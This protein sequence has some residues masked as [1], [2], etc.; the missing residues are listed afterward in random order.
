MRK[1]RHKGLDIFSASRCRRGV[2]T[3]RGS[4]SRTSTTTSSAKNQAE[5]WDD[6]PDIKATWDRLGI[7]EAEKN[8]LAGVA[9]QYESEVVYHKIQAELE[10]KGVIFPDMDGPP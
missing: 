3:S 6:L 8:Y 2:R 10:A 1:F 7:P 9:A 5:S 4:T